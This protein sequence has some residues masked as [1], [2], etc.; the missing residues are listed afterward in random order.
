[1]KIHKHA[2]SAVAYLEICKLMGAPVREDGRD[3]MFTPAPSPMQAPLD[4]ADASFNFSRDLDTTHQEFAIHVE[5]VL[6]AF[7]DLASHK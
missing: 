4:A 6:T 2:D 1:M 7:A 5:E 3:S